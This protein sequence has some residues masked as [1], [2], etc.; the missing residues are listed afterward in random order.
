MRM[1]IGIP[2]FEL[3]W[4]ADRRGC[5]G[6][7]GC[8]DV[9]CELDVMIHSRS[10]DRA[11]PLLRGACGRGPDCRRHSVNLA[12]LTCL[13]SLCHNSTSTSA[14]NSLTRVDRGA[15]P[16]VFHLPTPIPALGAFPLPPISPSPYPFPLLFTLQNITVPV[17]HRCASHGSPSRRRSP[18]PPRQPRGLQRAWPA[19]PIL[20][21]PVPA[22]AAEHSCLTPY[23]PFTSQGSEREQKCRPPPRCC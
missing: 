23:R 18:P 20:S 1:W 7:S 12:F 6:W 8:E 17:S 4:C 3:H 21:T 2:F 15:A 19:S 9:R 11:R 5:W 13:N 16:N 22:S 14:L 10:W